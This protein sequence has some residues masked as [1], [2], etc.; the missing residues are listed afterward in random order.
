MVRSLSMKSTK[1][2]ISQSEIRFLAFLM[3]REVG[4]IGKEKSLL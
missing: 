4:S 2:D 3:E 1:K